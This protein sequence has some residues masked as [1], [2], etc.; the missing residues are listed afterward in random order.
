LVLC[1]HHVFLVQLHGTMVFKIESGF[2]LF[3]GGYQYI[4]CLSACVGLNLISFCS[5]FGDINIPIVFQLV[6]NSLQ[7]IIFLRTFSVI[8]LIKKKKKEGKELVCLWQKMKLLGK[9]HDILDPR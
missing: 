3:S 4:Y 9:S 7:S 8:N 2:A 6:L 5:I 1:R